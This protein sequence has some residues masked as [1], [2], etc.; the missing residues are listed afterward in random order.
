MLETLKALVDY[1]FWEISI[2][3]LVFIEAVISGFVLYLTWKL[4]QHETRKYQK[5]KVKR[6]LKKALD[7]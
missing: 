7:D 1:G 5:Y 3:L 2:T 6:I 4:W